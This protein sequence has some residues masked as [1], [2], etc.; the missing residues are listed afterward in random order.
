MEGETLDPGVQLEG[1]ETLSVSDEEMA[2]CCCEYF[3]ECG[4]RRHLLQTF[5]D[6]AE[7]DE[8][9]NRSL[10]EGID[11]RAFWNTASAVDRRIR[12]PTWNGAKHVGFAFVFA[13]VTTGVLYILLSICVTFSLALFCI[14]PILMHRISRMI[15]RAFPRTRFLI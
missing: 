15:L 8:F 4:A 13:A 3:D 5:C 2:L 10:N 7:L 14:L 11:S 1:R 6:C 12:L 9:V